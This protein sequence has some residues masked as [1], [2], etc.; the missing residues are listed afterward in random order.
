M[1][2]LAHLLSNADK[3]QQFDNKTYQ[4]GHRNTGHNGGTTNRSVWKIKLEV[5]MNDSS[6]PCLGQAR[7]VCPS[8]IADKTV[9]K[10][11]IAVKGSVCKF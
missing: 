4:G 11:S 8:V 9:Q 10:S 3:P 6:S 1:V 5:V 7:V 2:E